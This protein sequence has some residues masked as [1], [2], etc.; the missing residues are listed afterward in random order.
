MVEEEKAKKEKK[1]EEAKEAKKVKAPKAE[2]AEAVKDERSEAEKAKDLEEKKR[3]M[4]EKAKEL[5]AGLK[6]EEKITAADVKVAKEGKEVQEGKE[7]EEIKLESSSNMLVP[8]DDYVKSGIYLG[9][10]VIT[11]DMRPYVFKRRTDGLAIINTRIVDEKIREA[12]SFISKYEPENIVVACKREA[13]WKAIKAFGK[14]TGIKVFTKKYPAG[15]ITN[16]VLEGFFEPS[17]MMIVDPWLDKNP[18]ADAN[19]I[20]VPLVGVCDTNNL[21]SSI[22]L[23]IPGNNKSGKSIGLIFWILARGYIKER[24]LDSKLPELS[25]FVGD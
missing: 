13:G 11:Q 15:I 1:K 22:D 20:N 7:A 21:T 17:L 14:A 9:T 8:L 2:K 10:K 6:G 3:R 18:M 4:A 5:A 24:K 25:E 12:V 19:K 23:V 16:S